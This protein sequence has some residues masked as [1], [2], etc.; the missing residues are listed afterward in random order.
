MALSSY[1]IALGSADLGPGAAEIVNDRLRPNLNFTGVDRNW[2]PFG[3]TRT[4][5]DINGTN[6]DM[7]Q[8]RLDLVWARIQGPVEPSPIQLERAAR[9]KLGMLRPEVGLARPKSSRNRPESSQVR[10][11]LSLVNVNRGRLDPPWAR[12]DLN[13]AVGPTRTGTA[14]TYA[15]RGSNEIGVGSTK[16]GLR[17]IRSVQARWEQSDHPP[18]SSDSSAHAGR[19]ANLVD[20]SQKWPALDRNRASFGRACANSDQNCPKWVDIGRPTR[21]IRLPTAPG[22]RCRESTSNVVFVRPWPVRRKAIHLS[23]SLRVLVRAIR[24]VDE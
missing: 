18:C 10:P 22:C 14:S 21:R 1:G 12:F 13:W 16:F 17:T 9:A 24:A 5:F 20:A 6:L 19:I 2:T 8:A 4:W 3:L 7:N 11:N 15:G 23:S